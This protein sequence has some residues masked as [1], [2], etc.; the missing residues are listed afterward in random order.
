LNPFEK[1]MQQWEARAE[2]L[3]REARAQGAEVELAFQAGRSFSVKCRAG[4]AEELLQSNPSGMGIRLFR[5]GRCAS[6]ALG[7]GRFV[8][9]AELVARLLKHATLL[10]QDPG[11]RL[12]DGASLY[13]GKPDMEA[14]D[15]KVFDL[16]L[17][18]A[19]KLA[20][21]C[22]KAALGHH[23]AV[24]MTEGASCAGGASL[25]AMY[26]S[27]GLAAVELTSNCSLS[28]EPV[29]EGADGSKKTS[30]WFSAA[31]APEGL[32]SP[33]AVGKK[34]GA[35]AVAKLGA[36]KIPSGTWPVLFEPEA[37]AALIGNLFRAAS[38]DLLQK[39][40]SYLDGAL[41]TRVGSEELT[42]IDDPLMLVAP[43]RTVFDSDGCRT[44]PLELF[45][46]GLFKAIPCDSWYGGKLGIP[47]T[48]HCARGLS[49]PSSVAPHNL[50]LKPGPASPEELLG[51]LGTGLLV[52][53]FI[54]SGF[55]PAT[56]DFSQGAEGFWVENGKIVH[57]VHEI[58]VGCRFQDF[59]GRLEAVGN[60]L[61]FR[62]SINA[63]TFLV[64]EMT[65]AGA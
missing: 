14:F 5:D 8:P 34:A 17:S 7:D 61:E 65:I 35:R 36:K 29:A 4:V 21:R 33:E 27:A 31:R 38:G 30:W 16:D 15:S 45:S 23:S 57:P 9:P 52:S 64:R 25:Q 46:G 11:N 18:S 60:D 3:L 2:G 41:G 1:T 24:T 58:T 50:Y 40:A 56:G 51:R 55:N 28:V 47:T 53:S 48:G 10:S 32:E 13:L 19:F 54:G 44:A 20:S 39:G 62:F 26:S 37:G 49:G 43:G 6:A 63:P 42:L 22:E 12:P 59:W